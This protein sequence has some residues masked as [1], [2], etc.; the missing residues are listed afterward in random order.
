MVE[1]PLS[2]A[3]VDTASQV[4]DRYPLRCLDALHLATCLMA[5]DTLGISDIYFVSSDQALL[6]A[7]IGENLQIFD[8]RTE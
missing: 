3:V 4:L 1:Q 2:P 7:A 6:A 5:R 8:P